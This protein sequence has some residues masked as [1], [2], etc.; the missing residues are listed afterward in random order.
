MAEGY[1][2]DYTDH[3][4]QPNP[5]NSYPP[6]IPSIYVD[7]AIQPHSEFGQNI[8]YTAPQQ[9][10]YDASTV[11][12]ASHTQQEAGGGALSNGG[13]AGPTGIVKN[14]EF[15]KSVP[16]IL[17]LVVIVLL[18]FAWI[19]MLAWRGHAGSI[20][21][22]LHGDGSSFF[23]FTALV[24]FFLI[25]GYVGMTFLGLDNGRLLNRVNWNLTVVI[26]SGVWAL[27]LI[28]S[29]SIVARKVEK[30]ICLNHNCGI[31]E[32]AAAFGF[33]SAFS[34]L[35]IVIYYFK[36]WREEKPVHTN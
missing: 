15:L 5:Q 13:Y 21:Y 2:P 17:N 11:R 1:T 16:G 26:H 23:L 33:L 27:M 25:I 24:P 3:E 20:F 6:Q 14:I 12:S 36:K 31:I 7:T 8:D 18:F 4:Q 9:P 29:S 30:L 10:Y 32:A 35:A 28:I 19:L 34:L 22:L